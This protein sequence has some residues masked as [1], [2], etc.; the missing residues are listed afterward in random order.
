MNT[1]H[2]GVRKREGFGIKRRN[3]V[4]GAHEGRLP[5]WLSH[6]LMFL[7]FFFLFICEKFA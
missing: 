5:G 1:D 4:T 7:V 6:I 2:T 3:G